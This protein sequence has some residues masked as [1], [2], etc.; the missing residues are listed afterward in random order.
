MS[1]HDQTS[2]PGKLPVDGDGLKVLSSCHSHDDH[3]HDH[4]HGK[5]DC[6]HT[7]AD[8]PNLAQQQLELAKGD[9]MALTL[10]EVF[11]L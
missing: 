1:S 4:G 6:T 9:L 3:A 7:C 11:G 10:R 5:D 8:C 2:Q